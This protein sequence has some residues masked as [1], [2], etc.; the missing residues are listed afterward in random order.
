M[1]C[2]Y[3]FSAG[4]RFHYEGFG[5]GS[6]MFGNIASQ[7]VGYYL[8][9]L[10]LIPLGYGHL[11]T[12]RW[13]RTLALTIGWTWLVVG[14]PL[15][16]VILAVLLG[17]K[18][19]SVGIVALASV[20]LAASYFVVPPVL[21]RFYN[22]RDVRLTF[23][24]R[25]PTS[26]WIETRPIPLLVLG[27]LD[28][29]YAILLHI[30]IFFQG[31][32]PL[33]GRFITGLHGILLLTLA[34]ACLIGLAWGAFR[35]RAWAWWGSLAYFGLITCSSTLTLLKTSY[36]ELLSLL[37]FPATE[38]EFLKGIPAQGFHFAVLTGL[39]LL[40]TLALILLARPAFRGS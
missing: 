31:L 37:Q 15:S 17:S 40:L 19:L 18:D 14:A 10:L 11:R 25:D 32:F 38:I 28:L 33:F 21:I 5:F 36:P 6:F 12:R 13:A 9:A 20:A 39:P 24:A 26:Y 23:E 34:I 16:L 1:Y 3:L 7:I 4:G 29:L 35:G 8:I 22:S 2:F 27:M 30:P